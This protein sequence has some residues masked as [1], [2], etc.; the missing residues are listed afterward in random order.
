MLRLSYM[1]ERRLNGW[2]NCSAKDTGVKPDDMTPISKNNERQAH[3][4][5]DAS[6]DDSSNTLADEYGDI[7]VDKNG[8]IEVEDIVSLV[9]RLVS[10]KLA[11][12]LSRY[13]IDAGAEES[14]A[15]ALEKDTSSIER[16]ALMEEPA[17]EQE[18]PAEKAE[19]SSLAEAIA[20]LSEREHAQA[21]PAAPANEDQ[22]TELFSGLSEPLTEPVSETLS[23]DLKDEDKKSLSKETMQMIAVCAA[24]IF[25][26]VILGIMSSR[27][28]IDLEGYAKMVTGFFED[29]FGN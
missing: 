22:I 26:A 5:H 12:E 4:N 7:L 19:V 6:L 9:D 27:G 24:T 20:L 2:N 1:S 14:V 13:G 23:E 28:I 29:I 3:I 25:G 18:P 15:N 8:K 11:K 17:V 10:Q 16:I 21:T